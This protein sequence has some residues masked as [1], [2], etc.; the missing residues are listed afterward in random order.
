MNEIRKRILYEDNHLI[1]INKQPK[2]LVQKDIT[3]DITLADK[4]KEYLRVTY[5]KPGNIYLGI[6]HRIDRPTSGIVIYTKTEKALVRMNALFRK[7]DGIKK[8]YW[9]VVDKLPFFTDPQIV[10]YITRDTK[11]NKSFATLEKRKNSQE[12]RMNLTI[13]G[14]SKTYYLLQVELITGRHHQ[15][16]A[17]LSAMNSHIKGDIKYGSQRT[18]PD[19]SIHLHARKVSFV[20]PVSQESITIVAP[21]PID[22]VWDYFAA[23]E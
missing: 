3:E 23:I 21:P 4:V 11:K 16:R 2:E 1:I 17:Q 6:P 9:A 19:G 13:V 18:N 15:I 10:H 22:P 20:H 7:E 5:K 14:A 8:W 12:A